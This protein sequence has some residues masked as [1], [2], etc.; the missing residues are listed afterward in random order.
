MDKRPLFELHAAVFLF[1]LSGLF[2]KMLLVS[3]LAIV[4]GR[5]FLAATALA[6][7]LYFKARLDRLPSGRDLVMI[8]LSGGLLAVHWLSFFY[9]IQLSTVAVGLLTFST[10]PVFVTFLEPIFFGEPLK[11]LDV[12]TAGAVF[13]GLTLVVPAYQLDNVGCSF[14]LFLC[15]FICFHKRAAMPF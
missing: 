8:C 13:A 1:G 6:V 4:F 14:Y 7:Y 2:G 11:R 10:F 3:P 5:T 15:R 9:S 12:F